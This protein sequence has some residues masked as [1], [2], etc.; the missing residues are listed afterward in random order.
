MFQQ[1]TLE[2]A[3]DKSVRLM[4]QTAAHFGGVIP[5]AVTL[6][7]ESPEMLDGFLKANALFEASTLDPLSRE[8][9]VMTVAVRNGCHLCVELHS[10]R[11]AELTD[12]AT[13]AVLRR[14]EPLD[15][16]R[17]EAV[18]VFTIKA[19]ESTGDVPD[20]DLEAFVAAGYTP[21]NALEVVLGIGTYTMST[22]ANRMTKATIGS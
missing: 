21:R 6:M 3:P 8:V 20:A 17:L 15:D 4:K 16:P 9:L 22:F 13:I 5:P 14:G 7:A 2:T 19:L 10:A 1:H 12:A 18:R 11:L